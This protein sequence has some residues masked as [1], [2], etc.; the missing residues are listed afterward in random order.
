MLAIGINLL[1]KFYLDL[2]FEFGKAENKGPAFYQVNVFSN[3]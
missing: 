1:Q 3:S 2:E